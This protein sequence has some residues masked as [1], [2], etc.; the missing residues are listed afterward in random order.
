MFTSG[1]HGERL[2]SF[3]QDGQAVG[4]GEDAA[5]VKRVQSHV[6]HRDMAEQ[7]HI[8][9]CCQAEEFPVVRCAVSSWC[10]AGLYPLGI[11][12]VIVHTADG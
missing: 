6:L 7:V 8:G 1:H 5:G 11:L 12:R 10:L 9:L 3:Q 4:A 2:F